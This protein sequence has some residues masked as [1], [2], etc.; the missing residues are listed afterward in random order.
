MCVVVTKFFAKSRTLC[1]KENF[2]N[3]HSK[4]IKDVFNI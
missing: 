1:V 2:H 4:F 3:Y